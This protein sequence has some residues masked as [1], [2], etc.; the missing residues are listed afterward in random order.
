MFLHPVQAA[1]IAAGHVDRALRQRRGALGRGHVDDVERGQVDAEMVH[2]PQE[3]VMRG[4]PQRHG[5]LL[6]G[7]V[8]GVVLG[9]LKVRAHDAVVVLGIGDRDGDGLKILPGRG[10]DD[11]G[12]HALADRDLNVARGHGGR[13]RC[14]GVEGAPVHLDAH[15]FVIGAH[16][17]GIFEGH[18]PFEEIGHRD[19]VERQGALGAGRESH[20]RDGGRQKSLLH[21]SLPVPAWIVDRPAWSHYGVRSPWVIGPVRASGIRPEPPLRAPAPASAAISGPSGGSDLDIRG[22]RVSW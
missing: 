9:D 13:H 16:L 10:G 18:R 5:D 1:A 14:A 21:V 12:R 22:A 15:L 19:F 6:A 20:G 17:L 7:K 4:G 3:A 8:G 2:L 11:E